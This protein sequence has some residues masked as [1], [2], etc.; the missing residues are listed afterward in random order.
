MKNGIGGSGRKAEKRTARRIGANL[1]PAS[2][3]FVEKGDMTTQEFRIESKATEKGSMSV[4]L[5]WLLKIEK[6][7]HMTG[8][9]PAL[10]II[11]CDEQGRP[12]KGGSWIAIPE[13]LFIEI[14]APV[15]DK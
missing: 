10:S 14:A 6:E 13:N 12:R 3:A 2:G 1:T 7:A 5:D 15:E 4:K 8:R 11:F 9:E